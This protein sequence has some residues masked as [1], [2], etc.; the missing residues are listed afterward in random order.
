MPGPSGEE[1]YEQDDYY[2]NEYSY[3]EIWVSE[4]AS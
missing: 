2:Y 1:D 3:D 4:A